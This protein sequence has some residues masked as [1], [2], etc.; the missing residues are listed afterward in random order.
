MVLFYEDILKFF[1]D[2]ID[3]CGAVL[4]ALETFLRHHFGTG[5]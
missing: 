2:D 4:L 1:G 3:Y 5:K